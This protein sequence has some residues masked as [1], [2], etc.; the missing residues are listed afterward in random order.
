MKYTFRK[1]EDKD[2]HFV[3]ELKEK[4]FKWYIE[5]IYGWNENTQIE[6]TQRE[7][8]E[9]LTDMSIKEWE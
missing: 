5:K 7:M 9:H 3:F 8:V 1:C 4:C 6:L 2:S